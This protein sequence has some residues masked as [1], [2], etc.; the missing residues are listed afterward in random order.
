MD[1]IKQMPYYGDDPSRMGAES[2]WWPQNAM[3]RQPVIDPATG[4]PLYPSGMRAQLV[5]NPLYRPGGLLPQMIPADLAAELISQM[6]K[7]ERPK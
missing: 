7:S 1:D 2:K 4:K 3:D 5:T 6:Q